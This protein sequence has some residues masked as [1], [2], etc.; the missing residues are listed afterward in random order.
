MFPNGS[1][2]LAV[3][4]KPKAAAPIVPATQDRNTEKPIRPT[5]DSAWCASQHQ[6]C[7]PR[8]RLPQRQPHRQKP[9]AQRARIERENL[10]RNRRRNQRS[11]SRR[12]SRQNPTTPR[13]R[14]PPRP[15]TRLHRAPHLRQKQR[16]QPP[17]PRTSRRNQ[18]TLAVRPR[19]RPRTRALRTHRRRKA[20]TRPHPH[21][22]L[23]KFLIFS[24]MFVGPSPGT[25]LIVR[26]LFRE[27][28]HP[29]HPNWLL[30]V[31]EGQPNLLA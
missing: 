10:N 7:R 24:K 16:S 18:M 29:A 19:Q 23:R 17:R 22:R 13:L 25:V 26:R 6:R 2:P 8:S 1:L 27:W 14:R 4:R 3:R 5:P 28:P 21:R 20:E 9:I 31:R 11:R 30:S 15:R 12:K